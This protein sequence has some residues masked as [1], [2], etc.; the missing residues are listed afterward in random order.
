MNTCRRP[1]IAALGAAAAAL[2][3]LQPARAQGKI[4]PGFSQIGAESE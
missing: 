1:V 3:L 2:H 4:V